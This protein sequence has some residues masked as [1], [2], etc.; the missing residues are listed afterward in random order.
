M[1]RPSPEGLGDQFD[2]GDYPN[3]DTVEIGFDFNFSLREVGSIPTKGLP[4]WIIALELEKEREKRAAA[5]TEWRDTLR[6]AGQKVVD[7]LFE[8]LKPQPDGKRRKLFDSTVTNLQEYLDTYTT[9]DLAGDTEY[10]KT[11]VEP[12]QKLMHGVTTTKIR[13][14]ESLKQYIAEQADGIRKN[15]SKLVQVT[16]RKFR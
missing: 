6:F 10:Q 16:G 14:N 8:A 12:L 15:A 3:S 11:V 7:A 13:H 2:R 1:S 4:D 5:I 9:R